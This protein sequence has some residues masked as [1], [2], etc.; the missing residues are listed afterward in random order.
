MFKDIPVYYPSIEYAKENGE[1]EQWRESY[2]IN[3]DLKRYL[4]DNASNH[5]N[6]YRLNELMD[7]LTENYGVER[8]IYLIAKTVQYKG[9][10]DG[11]FFKSVRDRADAFS[12]PDAHTEAV[13]EAEKQGYGH[14]ADKSRAYISDIHSCILNDIFRELMKLE[15]KQNQTPKEAPEQLGGMTLG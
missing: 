13:Q 10:Y 4:E 12:Y 9:S 11:R 1:L 14:I 15:Q 6:T 8:S 3:L 5:Y 7:T 2:E